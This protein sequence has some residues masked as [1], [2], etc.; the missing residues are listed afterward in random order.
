ML[1][2]TSGDKGQRQTLQR[3]CDRNARGASSARGQS[4]RLDTELDQSSLQRPRALWALQSIFCSNAPARFQ[5]LS[6][7][8]L[9]KNF[10]SLY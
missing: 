9:R 3:G 2:V 7:I 8:L 5:T 4:L 10:T 1:S 6:L